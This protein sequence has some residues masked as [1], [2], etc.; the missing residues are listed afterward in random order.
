MRHGRS[1]TLKLLAAAILATSAGMLVTGPLAP[2]AT[3]EQAGQPTASTPPIVPDARIKNLGRMDPLEI[4]QVRFT[5]QNR[6]PRPVRISR[7]RVA[8]NC[9]RMV[10]DSMTIPGGGS[11]G[12]TMTVDLRGDTG[13]VHKT[14]LI[15]FEGYDR[16]IEVGVDGQ[17]Q[18]P[19]ESGTAPL[20][21]N[22]PQ[23]TAQLRSSLGRPVR[24]LSVH[25]EKP[26]ILSQVPADSPRVLAATV[27]HDFGQRA[28]L[29]GAFLVVTDAKETPLAAVRIV[30]ADV[31][32]RELP[33]IR[34]MSQLN[35]SHKFFNMG[36]LKKGE[37]Q[38]YTTTV[39]REVREPPLV[40]W[41][42]VDG[43]EVKVVSVE[44]DPSQ[45]QWPKA[46]TVTFTITSTIDRAGATVYAP[47]YFASGTREN[48]TALNRVWAAG[49]T[50]DESGNYIE[51]IESDGPTL[52]TGD[53]G[54]EALASMGQ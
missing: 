22:S 14:A 5:L 23:V 39:F 21:V 47:L 48:P 49:L 2:V 28:N 30:S 31:S 16:P 25:G 36:V 11:I 38:T 37:T 52:I 50:A 13:K 12:L 18:Y 8:C 6:S 46:Q 26:N 54:E 53:G 34:M 41:I 7:F 29:P 35:I 17:M 3:A 27:R 51:A 10:P 40:G 44:P 19:L 45:D 15:Y 20:R 4:A 32:R 1:R 9:T 33:F 42:P 24:L 43:L